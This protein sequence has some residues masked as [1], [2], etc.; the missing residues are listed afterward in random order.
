[1]DLT[2]ASTLFAWLDREIW[3]VTSHAGGRRG[4]LIA[5]FVDQAGIV[6]D[7]PGMVVSLGQ[8][9]HTAELVAASG[10]LALHLLREAN[11]DLVWQ[12]GLQSGRD[13]DKFEGLDV[14]TGGTG[15]PLLQDTIGWLEC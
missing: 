9:H 12:F 8:L 11:L 3:L 2:A 14:V 15:C 10:V 7:T 6:P 1:M 4:G 13:V 5:T